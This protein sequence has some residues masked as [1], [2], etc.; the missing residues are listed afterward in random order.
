MKQTSLLANV[1]PSKERSVR[2]ASRINSSTSN[3][4]FI[5]A[6]SVVTSCQRCGV[7]NHN[8]R[9]TTA[10]KSYLETLT[11]SQLTSIRFFGTAVR[12]KVL[13]TENGSDDLIFEGS[14]WSPRQT[15]REDE[16]DYT[17]VVVK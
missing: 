11:Q 16:R 1:G 3:A 5:S 8:T 15:L 6:R 4:T 9:K 12:I 10:A 17:S 7:F 14:P 13:F 2:A